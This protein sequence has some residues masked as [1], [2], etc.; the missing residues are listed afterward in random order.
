MK[1][2]NI[3]IIGLGLM[4]GSF[5]LALQETSESFHFVGLDHNRSHCEEALKLGLVDE[6]VQ[7]TVADSGIGIP[8]DRLSE[9]FE[10]F[11]QLD[12]T[13]TRKYGGTGLGLSLVKKILDAHGSVL[14]VT[15]EIDK[16][17]QF[18]FTL[19]SS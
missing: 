11:H 5:S 4:G 1:K 6:V 10:P 14:H 7:V 15:S 9:I 13:S 2:T 16:G 8:D 17:S 18:N 12:G 19:N 3:G